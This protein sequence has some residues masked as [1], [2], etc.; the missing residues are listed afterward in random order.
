M[1]EHPT[2]QHKIEEILL[3]RIHYQSH[4]KHKQISRTAFQNHQNPN[5]K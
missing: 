3:E 2:D 5:S 1:T 4:S